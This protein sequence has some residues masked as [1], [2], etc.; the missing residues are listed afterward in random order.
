MSSP[1]AMSVES[2][3]FAKKEK[4]EKRLKNYQ[5]PS[6][7]R[8]STISSQH[9]DIEARALRTIRSSQSLPQQE[10]QQE[11]PLVGTCMELEKRY[12]RLTSVC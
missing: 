7:G 1:S 11:E 5:R 8:P 9:A 4:A 6:E 10:Q 3:D 2:E 12:L